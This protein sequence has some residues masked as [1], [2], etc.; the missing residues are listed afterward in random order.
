MGYGDI[1]PK[2]GPARAL[3][4]LESISGRTYL[5][6]PDRPLWSM[7]SPTAIRDSRQTKE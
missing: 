4:N 2:S 1:L 3:S 6:D 7:K 5:A